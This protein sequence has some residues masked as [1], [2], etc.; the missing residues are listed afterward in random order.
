MMDG[1]LGGIIMIALVE[2]GMGVLMIMYVSVK[3]RTK[4]IGFR[5]AS[6]ATNGQASVSS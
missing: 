3:E 2:A 1:A 4:E 6:G 5:K